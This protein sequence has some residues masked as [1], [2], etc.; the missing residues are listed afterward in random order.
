[1]IVNRALRLALALILIAGAVPATVH[2]NA[3]REKGKPVRI[4]DS[5]LS[6]TP[7]RDWNQ[8][9]VK[10]GKFAETWT[11]D[12][13][14]LNDVTFYAGVEPG[15]PLVRERNR[16]REPLPKFR[17]STLLVEVPEL[18]EGTYRAYR[19]IGTFT[20]TASRP[21]PFLGRD[22]VAFS[23]DYLDSDDLPR[24][25][26]AVAAIVNGRLYMMTF[27]APRLHFFDRTVGG[28]RALVAGATLAEGK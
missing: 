21:Q 6:V 11:L 9:G 13:E 10:P 7:P 14:Q 28:Y 8:L 4:K 17:G 12:G 19:H 22:G 24:K 23:Y 3:F 1:M 20:V 2:A 15:E 25:G 26:E 16:K 5:A 27:D 18:L